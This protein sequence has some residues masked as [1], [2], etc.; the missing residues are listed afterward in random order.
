MQD[1]MYSALFG[2]LTNEHRLN[3]IANNL[4]NVNTTGY[5]RDVLAFKDTFLSFA[6]DE[7]MEPIPNVRS[8][9]MFPEP[10]HIA[11]PRIALAKTDF[12]QGGLKLTG[13]PLDVAI[14]GEGFFK[15]RTP[16][17]EFYTRNGNFR[18]TFDGQLVT[19]QGWPVIGTGGDIQ[20]PP[21]SNITIAENGSIYANGELVGQIQVVNIDNPITLEKQGSNLFRLREGAGGQEVPVENPMVL[22]GF[23]EAANV[24]VVSEMVNMIE[25]HRQFEAYQ[26][27]MQATDAVDKMATDKV[28]RARV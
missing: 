9:K 10:I 23:T 17:G 25:A 20:L 21:R 2:A 14:Q 26:K 28:G 8:K 1:S 11:K 5:K 18:Q 16:E 13:A 15:V 7:V 24:E 4:A 27:I 12:T 19:Q 6:H 3:N 22:Q